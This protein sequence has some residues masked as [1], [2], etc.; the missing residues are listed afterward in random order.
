MRFRVLSLFPFTEPESDRPRLPRSS[1]GAWRFQARLLLCYVAKPGDED[2]AVPFALRDCD[3][4]DAL[5]IFQ[6]WRFREGLSRA[7][8]LTDLPPEQGVRMPV[9]NTSGAKWFS[10]GDVLWTR[11][12]RSVD[13]LIVDAKK[14]LAEY[15]AAVSA[16]GDEDK[17]GPGW[18]DRYGAIL[19]LWL[20]R[21]KAWVG[22][23][24]SP[25]KKLG[26]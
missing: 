12:G 22:R 7:T 10:T 3:W 23:H 21:P 25:K 16:D 6:A 24:R 14:W 2:A 11:T 4:D 13:G 17:M 18:P 26:V 19:L 1:D 15:E 9:S 5:V 20:F 8:G